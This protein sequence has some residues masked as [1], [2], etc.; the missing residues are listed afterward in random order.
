[1]DKERE[2]KHL[3][4][5]QPEITRKGEL[6]RKTKDQDDGSESDGKEILKVPKRTKR[7]HNN[8]SDMIQS[9]VVTEH[10]A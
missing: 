10:F 4:N 9:Q 1:M 3:Y 5:I 6:K 2:G 7:D 8:T